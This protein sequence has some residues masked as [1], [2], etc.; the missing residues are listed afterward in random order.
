[1]PVFRSFVQAAAL[2]AVLAA[3]AGPVLAQ[4]PGA[5]QKVAETSHVLADSAVVEQRGNT[6]FFPVLGYTPD[7]SVLF[8]ATMLRFFYLDPEGPNTRPSLFSPVFVYTAKNQTLIFLGTDLNWGG[9]R[10]HAGLVP[11]YQKF[12]DQF[13]GIGRE[14]PQDA[15]EDYTPEQFAFEGELEREVL[16]EL[17]AGIAYRVAQHQLLE[18]DAGGLLDDEAVTGTDKTVVSAPSLTLAW[19][20]RDNTWSSRRGAWVRARTAFYRK[21]WGSDLR[22]TDYELDARGYL[23]LGAKGSLAGQLLYHA[24][25]GDTPFF[26]LPRLGGEGGLRG[27]P[28]GRYMDGTLALARAEWRSGEVWGRLGGVVFTGLGDVA[29]RPDKLTT[30]AHLYT[31]GAGLRFT[32]SRDELV[33]IRLDMGWGNDASG[34]YLSVGEAF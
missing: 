31:V 19:D 20:T 4:A 30:A 29:S 28:G 12:P 3:W 8:G 23:P 21:G 34:F 32:L 10:W 26:S 9:G 22:W 7:T 16:G 18:V 13:Y 1:M 25:D 2:A 14:A 17:R 15:E 27:Y 11:S 33:K 24:T 6:V 5:E